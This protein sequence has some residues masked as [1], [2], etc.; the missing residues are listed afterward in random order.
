MDVSKRIRQIIREENNATGP[1]G[2]GRKGSHCRK[3]KTVKS[4]KKRCAKYTGGVAIKRGGT[5]ANRR[6]AKHSPWIEFVH[7]WQARHPGMSWKEA[8]QTASAPYRQ[9]R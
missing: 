4:G 8:L 2:T 3:Y 5:A 1:R 7:Q 6:A 9:M